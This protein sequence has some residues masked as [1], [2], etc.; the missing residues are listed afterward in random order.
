[1]N[2]VQQIRRFDVIN[3]VGGRQAKKINYYLRGICERM[4][5]R[6]IG[7]IDGHQKCLHSGETIFASSRVHFFDV[8][9]DN[10]TETNKTIDS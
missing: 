9:P 2:C 8:L 5:S 10:F 7:Q 4:S 1:M 6:R 3:T